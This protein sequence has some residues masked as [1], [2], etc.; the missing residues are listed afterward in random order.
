MH[1]PDQRLLLSRSETVTLSLSRSETNMKKK[2]ANL[3]FWVLPGIL[4]TKLFFFSLCD[5]FNSQY[6]HWK[7]DIFFGILYAVVGPQISSTVLNFVGLQSYTV[8]SF[9]VLTFLSGHHVTVTA[10]TFQPSYSLLFIVQ[11]SRGCWATGRSKKPEP[12]GGQAARAWRCSGCVYGPETCSRYSRDVWS[13]TFTLHCGFVIHI[14]IS[15][16][17]SDTLSHCTVG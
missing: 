4:C 2:M 17:V 7:Q 9:T 12:G 13:G 10:A 3:E 5:F 16:W 15:L 1:C 6:K 8:Q 14:Y 11:R